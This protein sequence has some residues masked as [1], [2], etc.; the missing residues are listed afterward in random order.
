MRALTLAGIIRDGEGTDLEGLTAV[1]LA[2]DRGVDGELL[3]ALLDCGCD[4]YSQAGDGMDS[5]RL[6]LVCG[7]EDNLKILLDYAVANGSPRDHW[8]ANCHW[9]TNWLRK[10]HSNSWTSTFDAYM[11]ALQDADL[12]DAWDVD[13]HTLLFRAVQRGNKA[14]VSELLKFGSHPRA[15][16]AYGWA[17][18]HEAVRTQ[19]TKLVELLVDGGACIF[20]TVSDV[21]AYSAASPPKALPFQE[22]DAAVINAL[23]IAVG[24][25]RRPSY[26]KEKA[27]LSPEMVRLLLNI[28]L[29]PNQQTRNTA[30][31]GC[32]DLREAETP[33]QIMFRRGRFTWDDKFFEV[34]RIAD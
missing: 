31:L 29:D 18:I 2:A 22:P 9:M 32:W 23:H 33:L 8:V 16:D 10:Q 13:G 26:L 27:K 4:P 24:F 30:T 15:C 1:E 6:A 20:D 17:P 11:W 3:S 34:V 28:G 12:I 14:L 21:E 25:N 7:K 19:S 5:Y